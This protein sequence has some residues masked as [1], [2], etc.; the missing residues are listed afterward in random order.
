MPTFG[1]RL[2][3]AWNAFRGRDH[4][5]IE[6]KN[7]GASSYHRP[8]RPRLT[9]G[10]ERSIV[11]AIYNRIAIDVASVPIRHVR[12]DEN[13]RFVEVIHSKL[14]NCLNVEA[15]TD[16]TGRAFIQDI[17]MSMF[18]EGC[19]AVVPT[20]TTLD[21]TRSNSYEIE[22]MRTGRIVQWYPQ[23]VR[24]SVYNE[25]RGEKEEITLPKK[26]VAII[27]NP[28]YAIINEPNST[29]Q[30]LVRKLA[31]MDIVDE[32]TSASKLDLIIQLP[33]ELKSD[34]RRAQAEQ[35]RKDIEE[36]LTD[37]KYGIAYT[38]A[39]EHVTQLNRSLENNLL[40]Q[41][42]YLT[43]MLYGQL[44]LTP[45]ILN[46]TADEMIMRNYN[47]RT[48]EPILSAIADE[49]ERKF[50]TKTARTQ[51]QGIMFTTDP[52]RL[53]PMDTI[54]NMA[55]VFIRNEIL[56]ANEI[57]G[58]VGFKPFEDERADML[59]NPNMPQPDGMEDADGTLPPENQ[60]GDLIP[61]EGEADG[62]GGEPYA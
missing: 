49:F 23:H 14:H 46:G 36:Q 15:N 44:G 16:Q 22:T 18:D 7:L 35:R 60:N 38:S 41:V 21:P 19:V 47:V 5:V 32:Q 1:E 33:Y 13:D 30:R 25:Q 3:H 31:L 54:A 20:D 61:P 43:N 45:E 17:V 9:R 4:P 42:E 39:T 56:S 27:E 8:D 28:L 62:Y 2:S 58:L 34:L 51:G 48:I 29:M 11:T 50:L 10:N 59:R 37:S 26:A 57:R 24:V 53:V 6:Y 40:E 12:L 55:D 52:F